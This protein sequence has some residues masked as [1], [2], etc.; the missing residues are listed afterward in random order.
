MTEQN[1]KPCP[2]CGG[3]GTLHS[4]DMCNTVYAV[5]MMCGN[6][7]MD[8]KHSENAIEAWNRRANNV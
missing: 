6:R 3:V 2:F 4:I 7:T 5:C 1:L 8:Y